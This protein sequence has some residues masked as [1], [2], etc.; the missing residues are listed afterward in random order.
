MNRS[1]AV[2]AVVAIVVTGCQTSATPSP[3]ATSN[4]S[5]PAATQAGSVPLLM[6]LRL[7]SHFKWCR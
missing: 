6:T 2:V 5:P 7:S 1:L 4:T 3:A